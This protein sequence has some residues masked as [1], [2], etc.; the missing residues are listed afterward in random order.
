M[1]SA[2]E[3]DNSHFSRLIYRAQE[4]M[5]QAR[6]LYFQQRAEGGANEETITYLQASLMRYY[7]VMRRYRDESA[8]ED[9]W[10]TEQFRQLQEH[11][12]SEERVST[13]SAGRGSRQTVQT[14]PGRVDP[15]QAV[16]LSFTLDDIATE[17]GFAAS[18]KEVTPHTEATEDDLAETFVMRLARGAGVDGLA[19]MR[20]RWRQGSVT[21][22]RPLLGVSRAKLRDLLRGR[23]ADWAEDPTNSDPSYERARVRDGLPALAGLGLDAPALAGAARRLAEARRALDEIAREK[24][25]GIVRIAAGDVLIDRA[26]LAAL[27]DEVARRILCAAL[28]WINGAEYGP[29]GAAMTTFLQAA[30]AGEA[31][32]LQGCLLHAGAT[33]ARIGREYN[34]VARLRGPA[35]DV[36]DGRWRLRG[37]AP[38]GAEIAALGP[39]GLRACPDW[40]DS[41]L[42]HASALASPALWRDG[43]LLAAP[44]VG[45]TNGHD[46]CLVRDEMDF[47]ALS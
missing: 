33:W 41:G 32:T 43:M 27:P 36:W 28:A 21:F 42:A 17:L 45:W 6:M 7:S 31:M 39:A 23:G 11:V 1:A 20:D 4:E 2:D 30:R 10:P 14:R 16:E 40:R 35:R 25:V 19:A 46:I 13:R 3:S 26:G 24:A 15:K 5:D 29:R 22:H 38:E 37:P 44:L 12:L 34:A 8:I 47:F 18:P 9:E